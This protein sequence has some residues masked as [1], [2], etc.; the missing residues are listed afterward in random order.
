MNFKEKYHCSSEVW[1]ST[2]WSCPQFEYCINREIILKN[3]GINNL[4]YPSPEYKYMYEIKGTFEH[5]RFSISL[6][7]DVLPIDHGYIYAHD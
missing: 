4:E 5:G 7:K 3:A 2:C 1:C 6:D